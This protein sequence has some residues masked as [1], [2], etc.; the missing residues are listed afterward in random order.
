MAHEFAHPAR[1][2]Y[3]GRSYALDNNPHN[4]FRGLEVYA[5]PDE[6][7]KRLRA[8]VID[9]LNGAPLNEHGHFVDPRRE[10]LYR[11]AKRDE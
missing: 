5:E 6:A 11:A 7:Y 3:G 8:A 10:A 9:Y 2:K 4:D 1:L